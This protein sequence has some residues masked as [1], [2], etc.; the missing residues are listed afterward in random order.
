MCLGNQIGRLMNLLC[1]TWKKFKFKKKK[2]GKMVISVENR[3]FFRS[4]M[5]KR[6]SPLNLS[7]EI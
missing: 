4:W 7:C 1:K 3:K 5:T 6:T 2:K